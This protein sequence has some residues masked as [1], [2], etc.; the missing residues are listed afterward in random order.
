MT[1]KTFLEDFQMAEI[2]KVCATL[3][4]LLELLVS[5]NIPL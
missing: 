4:K 2:G 1:N 5:D 3:A